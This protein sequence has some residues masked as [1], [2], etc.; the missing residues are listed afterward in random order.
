MS[1]RSASAAYEPSVEPS[2]TTT[3]LAFGTAA[4]VRLTTSRSVAAAWNAG[5]TATTG[6]SAASPSPVQDS[7]HRLQL[8]PQ[9]LD[10]FGCEG[11]SGLRLELS[12][13]AVLL[14]LLAGSFDLVLLSVQQVLHQHDQLDL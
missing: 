6:T 5:I 8:G 7:Q 9:L 10:G 1:T 4:R 11:T 12:R 13:A 3:T 2:F 14:D